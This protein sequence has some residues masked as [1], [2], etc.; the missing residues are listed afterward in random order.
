MEPILNIVGSHFGVILATGGA[1]S[2][3]NAERQYC[4]SGVVKKLLDARVGTK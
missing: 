2:H 4:F 3:L 1:E